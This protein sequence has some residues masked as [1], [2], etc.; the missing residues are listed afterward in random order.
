VSGFELSHQESVE[1]LRYIFERVTAYLHRILNSTYMHGCCESD[2]IRKTRIVDNIIDIVENLFSSS[3]SK[4]LELALTPSYFCRMEGYRIGYAWEI[5]IL[6][7]VNF[8]GQSKDLPFMDC[9]SA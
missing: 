5:A 3:R 2:Q 7:I 6:D 1:P 9:N 4:V 8:P